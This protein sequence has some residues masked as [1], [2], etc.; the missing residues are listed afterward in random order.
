MGESLNSIQHSGRRL[1]ISFTGVNAVVAKKMVL[2]CLK[3]LPKQPRD[4]LKGY[5][6]CPLPPSLRALMLGKMSRMIFPKLAALRGR[7]C[8][9]SQYLLGHY[10]TID[11]NISWVVFIRAHHSKAFAMENKKQVFLIDVQVVWVHK[12]ISNSLLQLCLITITYL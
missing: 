4:R 9:F 8:R 10:G 3:G 5:L 6:D 12:Y 7:C 11:H 1:N 2:K